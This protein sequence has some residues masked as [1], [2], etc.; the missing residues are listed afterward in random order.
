MTNSQHFE[1][2]ARPF[3]VMVLPPGATIPSVWAGRLPKILDAST[4][5]SFHGVA[6]AMHDAIAV[7]S[8]GK[9]TDEP[10]LMLI[11]VDDQTVSELSAVFRELA[12]TPAFIRGL[13]GEQL[14]ST[15]LIATA[16]WNATLWPDVEK[17]LKGR[18]SESDRADHR[19]RMS[20]AAET[21]H[22]DPEQSGAPLLFTDRMPRAVDD[23]AASDEG[24]GSEDAPE[25]Y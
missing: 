22:K 24:D 7:Q 10:M 13:E 15:L 19:S 11:R 5:A 1:P 14:T 17:R 21:G 16:A 20:H 25:E 2:S 9:P 8:A 18:A 23:E 4:A 12:I 3:D 6:S